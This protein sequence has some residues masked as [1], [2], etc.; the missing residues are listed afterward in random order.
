M[1]E[2]IPVSY[3]H[4]DVYKRQGLNLLKYI[5]FRAAFAVLLS[6]TIA[7]VYGKKIINYLRNKQMGELVRDLG[8]DGQKQKEGTPTMG[9]LIIIFATIIP[10]LLFT[11]ITNVYIICLLYT[12]RC[13]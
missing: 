13:V 10:V 6:L 9:G 4:L 8:L 12:S 3:T 7:L 2:V 5:S 11:R 1:R